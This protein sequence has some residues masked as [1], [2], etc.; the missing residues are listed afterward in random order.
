MSKAWTRI[1]IMRNLKCKLDITDQSLQT[2][3][4]S[5]IKPV[6]EYSDVVSENCTLYEANE[7]EKIQTEATRIVTGATKLVFIDSLYTA[8]GLKTLASRRKKE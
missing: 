5:F 7:L 3:Y 2:I 8:T 6:I 4:F 1:Y